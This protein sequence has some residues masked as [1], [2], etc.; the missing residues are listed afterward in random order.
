ME[1]V[2]D[3]HNPP[4]GKS[5]APLSKKLTHFHFTL[6]CNELWAKRDSLPDT[7][8]YAWMQNLPGSE[9]AQLQGFQGQ[10]S[11]LRCLPRGTSTTLPDCVFRWGLQQRLGRDALGAGR[12]RAQP[13]CGAVLDP[14]GLHAASCN[15]GQVYK[16]HDKLRDLIAQAAR[17]A[18]MAAITEQNMTTEADAG[19]VHGIHRADVRIIESVGR[20]LWVDVKVIST[21]PKVAIKN[22]LCQAE[23]AKCKQY[24]QGPPERGVLHGEMLPFIAE[25]HGKLAPMAGK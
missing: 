25:A 22:A 19:A 2:G 17:Q 3:I 11:W 1:V 18:G 4:L 9:P 20:Q 15:W 13:G 7:V 24:G 6:S 16:R 21:K 8:R 14:F 23:V 5:F 10:G 12:Q